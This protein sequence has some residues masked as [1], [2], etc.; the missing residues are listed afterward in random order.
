MV[1]LS[2]YLVSL[3]NRVRLKTVYIFYY[4]YTFK[5]EICPLHFKSVGNY[6]K[7]HPGRNTYPQV[8]VRNNKII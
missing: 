6:L 7:I 1:V 3:M 5:T 4:G 8:G 2:L